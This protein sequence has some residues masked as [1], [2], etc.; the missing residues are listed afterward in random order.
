MVRG[1]KPI[2]RRGARASKMLGAESGYARSTSNMKFHNPRAEASRDRI[3]FTA[4]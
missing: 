1:A 2:V 4:S 3:R